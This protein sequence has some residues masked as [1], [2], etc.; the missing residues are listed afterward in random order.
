MTILL[1]VLLLITYL[2][3]L[4]MT[5]MVAMACRPSKLLM[6]FFLLL[7]PIALPIAGYMLYNKFKPL[8]AMIQPMA[9]MLLSQDTGGKGTAVDDPS[10]EK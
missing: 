2:E 9:G 8:I 1:L 10:Y 7:W 3:G 5:I 4:L 6:P